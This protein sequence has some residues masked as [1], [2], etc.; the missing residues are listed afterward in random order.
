[1]A[2]KALAAIIAIML[3]GYI[4]TQVEAT[5]HEREYETVG[6]GEF[7][8]AL[9][10]F[11]IVSHILYANGWSG[12]AYGSFRIAEWL[13]FLVIAFALL[14]IGQRLGVA[15]RLEKS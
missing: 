6:R 7:V 12:V 10:V 15:S 3:N 13:T 11:P 9:I 5:W 14:G 2:G 1:M 4:G 8:L